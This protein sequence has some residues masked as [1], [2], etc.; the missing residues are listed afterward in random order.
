VLSQDVALPAYNPTNFVISRF[1]PSVVF[2]GTLGTF[3]CW[4]NE[5]HLPE[6][7]A[8]EQRQKRGFDS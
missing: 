6:A 7:V 5:S 4:G 3:H 8:E 1:D 2:V